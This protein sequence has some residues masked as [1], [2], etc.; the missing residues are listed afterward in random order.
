M[1]ADRWGEETA[2]TERQIA[3]R[4]GTAP[5]PPNAG[6]ARR[7]RLAEMRSQLANLADFVTDC[8]RYKEALPTLRHG[9][10]SPHVPRLMALHLMERRAQAV[11][12]Q[13]RLRE[14]LAALEAAP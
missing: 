5:E 11:R 1:S 2:L 6:E 4:D 8:D 3:L 14:D 12:K 13:E 10:V 9:C 7:E